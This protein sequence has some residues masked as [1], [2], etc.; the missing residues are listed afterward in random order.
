[1]RVHQNTF[2][3]RIVL[4]RA[5]TKEFMLAPQIITNFLL[6][7][8]ATLDETIIIYYPPPIHPFKIPTRPRILLPFP[9]TDCITLPT[10]YDT[11]LQIWAT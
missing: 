9:I 10:V 2:D 11:M 6:T 4:S 8:S 1:M 7:I 5:I 3:F